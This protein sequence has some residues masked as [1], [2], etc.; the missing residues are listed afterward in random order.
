M[1]LMSGSRQFAAEGEPVTRHIFTVIE[2]SGDTPVYG[3]FVAKKLDPNTADAFH[4]ARYW[5]NRGE[6]VSTPVVA[7][8][9]EQVLALVRRIQQQPVTAADIRSLLDHILEL[10]SSSPHG[11]AWYREYSKLYDHWVNENR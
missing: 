9:I 7:L 1:T 10:Q 4:Q 5:R 6:Y 11:P 8:E 3:L 2:N